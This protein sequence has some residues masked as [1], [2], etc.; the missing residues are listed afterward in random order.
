MPGAYPCCSMK[1]YAG[2]I[3]LHYQAMNNAGIE[4]TCP[5]I[6]TLYSA[7][8]LG[9]GEGEGGGGDRGG[10]RGYMGGKILK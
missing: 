1:G 9:Q 4:A 5:P 10:E 6:Y 2:G 8:Y 3:P 7:H